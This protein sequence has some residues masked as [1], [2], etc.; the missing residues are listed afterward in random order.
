MEGE[1]LKFFNVKSLSNVFVMELIESILA[2]HNDV[3]ARHPE[4]ADVLRRR[5]MPLAMRYV[6][7]KHKF[8]VTVR[9]A[10]IILLLFRH[11]LSLLAVESDMALSL[12]THLLETE[13][14]PP[15][16]RAIC[17]EVFRNLYSEPALVRQIYILFDQQEGRK[18][19]LHD[20]TACLARLASEKPSLI[21]VTHQSSVPTAPDPS[22]DGLEDQVSLE[23]VGVSSVIG[24]PATD[25][26]G[27]GISSQ[28]S[29]VRIPYLDTLDKTD[30]PSPP[31]T[32]I[33]T[34]VLNCIGAFSEGVAKFIL[35]LTASETKSKRR[36]RDSTA[37]K[38]GAHSAS[39]S[40]EG[41]D[42]II[43][44]KM[45]SVPLNP[46]DLENHA[47]ITDI[48][49]VAGMI[50]VCWPAVL[51]A[52]S[53]FLYAAM[54][55]EFY[56]NLVRAFQ[57][58]THVAGLLRLSTPRN[59]FLTTL[60]KAAVPS[61]PV[62]VNM[63]GTTSPVRESQQ[64]RRAESPSG[65]SQ[66]IAEVASTAADGSAV[67]LTTRNL[68]CLRALLNLGI[69]LGPTFDRSSWLIVLETLQHAELIIN[70]S[71]LPAH[72]LAQPSQGGEKVADSSAESLK[73]NVG[74]EIMAVQSAATKMFESTGEYP[75]D[76][77]ETVLTALLALS[78]S[79]GKS[80]VG[81]AYR[82]SSLSPNH[83][84]SSLQVRSIHR[85]RRSVSAGRA[86][87]KMQDDELKF[88]L[89][90]GND[91]SRANIKRLAALPEDEH[92]WDVLVTSLVE[93][94]KSEQIDT[95]LRLKAADVLDKVVFNT[96][97][98]SGQTDTA[99]QNRVQLRGLHALKSQVSA[100][101]GVNR[102]SSAA[103]RSVETEIHD[104]ALET[105]KSALEEC[106]ESVTSGWPLVFDLISTVF[107][108]TGSG[109]IDEPNGDEPFS[110]GTRSL[111]VR[112]PKLVRTAYDSLQLVASDFLGLLPASCLLEMIESFSKFAAQNEE[113]NIS[114]ITT[115]HFW[116]V[117]DFL[118]NRM[119]GWFTGPQIDVSSSEDHLMTIGKDP[120]LVVSGNALWILL[121]LRIVNVSI[122]SRAEIRNG[123]VHT[124]LRIMDQYGDQLPPDVWN[125]CLNRVLFVM[126]EAIQKKTLEMVKTSDQAS[127]A[128]TT[129]VATRGLSN[130]IVNYF[131]SIIQHEDF[132]HSWARLLRYFQVLISLDVLE[133]RETAFSS[134]AEVLSRI[135]A[136]QEIGLDPL[137]AAWG[138]WADYRPVS[139]ND[140][141]ETQDSN[142]EALLAYIRSFK[143]LYRLLKDTLTEDDVKKVLDKFRISIWESVI[144]R[145][146]PDLDRM[147]DLQS[148][149]VECLR[150]LCSDK[151]PSQPAIIG[152]LS[153]FSDSPFTKWSPENGKK[154]PTFV[155][156]SKSIM[157]LL[158]WYISEHGIKTDILTNGAICRML[159]R[160][161]NPMLN[162]YAWPGKDS[163]PILWQVATT[164]SLDVLQVAI[165]YVEERYGKAEQ[166][167]VTHTWECIVGITRGIITIIQEDASLHGSDISSDESFD[168]EAFQRLRSMIIPSLGASDVPDKV[169]REFASSLF[170]SSLIY[171]PQRHGLPEDS[172]DKEPLQN[173]YE[174]RMG[175]T[176]DPQ[177]TPR[178]NL[179]YVLIDTLFDLASAR[180]TAVSNKNA[181]SSDIQTNATNASAQPHI[182]IAKSISPYLI[183]RCAIPLKGYIADQPLRGLMP[184]P[185]IARAELLYLLRRL[186]ELRSEPAAIPPAG[187]DVSLGPG[188]ARGSSGGDADAHGDTQ[189]AST[190]KKH[191]GWIYP[192]ITRGV[193]VAGKET[194]DKS[195]LEALTRILG[196]VA[197]DADDSDDE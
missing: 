29:L 73:S 76:A 38:V 44:S 99:T 28:W 158:S 116:N 35:P 88:V 18:N 176:H 19:I 178:S 98:L 194:E 84:Q 23:A 100:L 180:P 142:Q 74:T 58:L 81:P 40:Q 43:A 62:N 152:C 103:L 20:N 162:K 191:L 8:S 65:R 21:G 104:L 183:L 82:K 12:L 37:T 157:R 48:T 186:V 59:A 109:P 133:L 143:Q 24:S 47:L 124:V 140:M 32:Y 166:K 46:L 41:K 14:S 91:L 117:S 25:S 49:A 170:Y 45:S 110:S 53:T 3:F 78:E 1:D 106:G 27:C 42:S 192:F 118:R 108:R 6:S 102:G 80:L 179:S 54:D 52:S 122:D 56:H 68:L 87:A 90:K 149:V 185:K 150:S 64:S 182:T 97:K 2:S 72:K 193:R 155:A 160:L 121:L 13:G 131:A 169:R 50:D 181:N 184:Q 138:V 125:L 188:R 151:T 163:R 154:R 195:V 86:K 55:G 79:T 112:S 83:A 22:N 77:F 7:E 92:V 127:W 85:N 190:Y 197:G 113:F 96:I 164:T 135:Q 11:H 167:V 187:P 75:D 63:S 165:P 139:Q 128:D 26:S 5:L 119:G 39:D 107:D 34:L 114:L 159:E 69:A 60:G 126:V 123:A 89:D 111:I 147:S 144:S 171:P 156:F 173:L 17:L 36:R 115:S 70:V 101:Y 134:F 93:T 161:A 177:P 129:V 141:P 57:K 174:I 189:D 196:S 175:R 172:I 95:S 31:E 120:D 67:S 137:K 148:L 10:R 9:S 145:Y 153:E 4:Q 61:D 132:D 130:L 15:W 168:I 51:A 146:S 66:S 94:T 136:S 33:Y 16:K 30:N 71:T 105:L